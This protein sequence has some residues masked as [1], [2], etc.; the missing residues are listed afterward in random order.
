MLPIRLAG[1]QSTDW[2][3]GSCGPRYRLSS[4]R[5][6]ACS[7]RTTCISR[8]SARSPNKSEPVLC[9]PG[10]R[11]KSRS[12][13]VPEDE[14]VIP[15]TLF[16]I[17]ERLRNIS[18]GSVVHRNSI[19]NC[20]HSWKITSRNCSRSHAHTHSLLCSNWGSGLLSYTTPFTRQSNWQHPVYN[21]MCVCV[22]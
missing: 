3:C 14:S 15:I 2:D 17:R 21:C 16:E 7:A 12:T 8:V 1:S 13:K 5:R 10:Q 11:G 20:S 18:P 22:I 4:V 6:T 9:G 19:T